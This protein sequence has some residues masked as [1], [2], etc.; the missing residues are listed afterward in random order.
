VKV[1]PLVSASYQ[2]LFGAAGFTLVALIAGEPRPAPTGDAWIAWAY[3]VVFGS[4]V[5][6]TSFV[7]A[8]HLLPMSLVTTYAY[9]NPVIALILGRTILDEPITA[10]T[11][12]GAALVISGVAGV[13]R[14]R[15]P[16]RAA[17]PAAAMRR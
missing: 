9:V 15:R 14:A 3:L 11:I 16:L 4:L 5:G 2:L 10:T 8:L 1:D 12:A 7:Q 6:F 17:P 13:F